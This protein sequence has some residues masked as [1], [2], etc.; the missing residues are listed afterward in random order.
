M[1]DIAYR[2]DELAEEFI[3][4]ADS[5]ATFRRLVVA[6]FYC[7]PE[8]SENLGYMGNIPI[9]GD[10]PGPT[11]DAMVHLHKTLETLSLTL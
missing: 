3:R 2:K 8:G 7:S 5:F 1:D 9:A 6:A 11:E 4:I 10:Y